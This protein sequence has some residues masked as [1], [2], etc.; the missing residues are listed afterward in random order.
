MRC[1][2]CGSEL[3]KVG[4]PVEGFQ[5]YRCPN[6][7]EEIFSTRVKIASYAS[8]TVAIVLF[9]IFF[10]FLVLPIAALIKIVEFVRKIFSTT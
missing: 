3:I 10:V 9:A 2:T 5:E 6:D 8:F 4:Y 7:C 1:A